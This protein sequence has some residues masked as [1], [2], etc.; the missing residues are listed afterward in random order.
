MKIVIMSTYYDKGGAEWQALYESNNLVK[1]GVEC[2]YITF[3]PDFR[4]EHNSNNS[5]NNHYQNRNSHND[6]F[7]AENIDNSKCVN[8][9]SKHINFGSKHGV[10]RRKFK[11]IF[12]DFITLR[13]LRKILENIQPDVI[14]LH[15]I[16]YNFITIAKACRGYYTI[17]TIHD[18]G[19]LCVNFGRCLRTNGQLCNNFGFVNCWKECFS[20]NLLITL[21][22]CYY[23]TI[24]WIARKYT[25]RYVK[26]L[27]S[28]SAILAQ[29]MQAECNMNI[30]IFTLNNVI[31]T[32]D[33]FAQNKIWQS[34]KKKIVFLGSIRRDKGI[35]EL[36]NA[37]KYPEYENLKLFIVGSLG[38]D[39][40]HDDFE[41]LINLSGAIFLGKM[42]HQQL[43]EFLRDTYA[44]IIPSLWMENYPNVALEGFA[45][46]CIVTGSNRGGIPE[47]VVRKEL[48]FDVLSNDSIKS[49]LKYI[50]KMPENERKQ[51]CA[52]QKEKLL[53]NNSPDTYFKKLS[54]YTRLK[55]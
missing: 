55:F 36:L 38:E 27:L 41:Q 15:N 11:N 23:A 26:L 22:F 53:E 8:K 44:V 49:V 19:N 7:N 2:W 31:D 54:E 45:S 4:R 37:Y 13:K 12:I 52:E 17:Q 20:K 21:V 18:F 48:L 30:P 34:E 51:I 3:D 43:V 33:F 40:N 16:S 14:H 42:N 35:Y 24:K 50:D 47:L 39:M 25:E 1:R 32:S 10:I 46:N 9:D 29:L 28:P 5:D 6:S